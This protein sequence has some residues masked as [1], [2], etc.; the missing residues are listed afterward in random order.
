MK[1]EIGKIFEHGIA[2]IRGNIKGIFLK[3]FHFSKATFHCNLRMF[4]GSNLLIRDKGKISLGKGVTIGKFSSLR[5]QGGSIII[6]K[7]VGINQNV[8]INA[9]E[10]IT[11]GA[12][13]VIA[14]NVCIYDHDHLF[15]AEKG[16]DKKHFKS[17]PIVIGSGVWI[18]AG[19][20]ILRGTTIGNNSVVGAGTVLKGDYP[21]NSIIVQEKNIKCIPMKAE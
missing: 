3:I 11:I 13:T 17:A 12:D 9:H 5:A 4:R 16:V 19:A 20:I 21:A 7:G 8:M 14:P 15:G 2:V 10:S 1:F 18:G 6:E